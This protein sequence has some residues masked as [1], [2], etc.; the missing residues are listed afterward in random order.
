[1]VKTTDASTQRGK[2]L[3]GQQ[4]Q[5]Q[6]HDRRE[7]HLRDLAA[8]A[9]AFR[10]C[11]LC[12]AAV[13]DDGAAQSGRGIRCRKAQDVGVR[14]NFLPIAQRKAARGCRALRDDHD[15]A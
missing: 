10:H 1:M 8:R 7:N 13:D 11:G 9:H 14:I 12:R 2:N 15:E 4:E 6:Q 5:H 3:S